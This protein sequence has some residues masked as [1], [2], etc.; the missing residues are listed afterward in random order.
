MT[1][2]LIGGSVLAL[3][4]APVAYGEV[5]VEQVSESLRVAQEYGIVHYKEMDFDDDGSAEIEGWLD[6]EWYVEIEI[7]ANG[8]VIQEERKRRDGGPTGMTLSEVQ[9]LI[10]SAKSEGITLIEEISVDNSGQIELEGEN[11]Q[12]RDVDLSNAKSVMNGAK[13]AF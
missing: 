4:M 3:L 5:P 6:D 12:G 2:T 1:K 9:N 13:E 10:D 8:E 7:S 11:A